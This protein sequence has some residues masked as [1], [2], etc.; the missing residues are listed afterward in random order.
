MGSLSAEWRSLH[1][2]HPVGPIEDLS[3]FGCSFETFT[4]QDFRRSRPWGHDEIKPGQ[5]AELSSTGGS[6]RQCETTALTDEGAGPCSLSALKMVTILSD[7]SARA[8]SSDLHRT[9]H[10]AGRSRLADLL[11]ERRVSFC[12]PY[13]FPCIEVN[14]LV[15]IEKQKCSE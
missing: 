9:C 1:K 8:P 4:N 3:D 10:S 11:P 12:R 2:T 14:P 13:A 7:T 6:F 5:T 15:S